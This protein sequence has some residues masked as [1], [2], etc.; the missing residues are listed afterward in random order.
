MCGLRVKIVAKNNFAMKRIYLLFL[1]LVAVES[2]GQ[3]VT[4]F[5]KI[6]YQ[7]SNETDITKVELRGEYTIIH[8]RY[9]M[10]E[11]RRRNYEFPIPRQEQNKQSTTISFNPESYLNGNGKRYRY[12]KSIGIAE[13]TDEKNQQIVYP[14]E[15]YRFTVYFERLDP[16]IELF[17]LIEGK[18]HKEQSLLFWNFYGI[19]IL[20]PSKRSTPTPNEAV[21]LTIKGRLIDAKTQKSI[22][23]KVVYRVDKDTKSAGFKVVQPNYS[24]LFALKPDT[25]TFTATATGYETAETSMDLSKLKKAQQFTQD[26]YLKPV[27]QKPQVKTETKPLPSK[28]VKPVEPPVIAAPKIEVPKEESA[29]VRI[30]VNK[31]RLDKVYFKI[32]ESGIL[33]QSYEQLH[34]LLKMMK[35]SQTMT[36]IIEGHTDNVGDADE[37]KRLSLQR[38][39]NVREYLIK[40]GIAGK[41]IQFKGYGDTKPIADNSTEEGRIQNRRVEF[42]IVNP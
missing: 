39:F 21:V 41:S 12:L 36:I 34:G 22:G 20:N 23:G 18:N 13:L 33:E 26:I 42:V 27:A 30:E 25:Y 29:P 32:G 31:F 8:F 4:E 35:E 24:F 38:A 7:S 2:F 16:G 28:T 15:V 19:H 3:I 6:D 37:N 10:R 17:N 5:P 40:R 14:G 1:I 9:Q 11:R